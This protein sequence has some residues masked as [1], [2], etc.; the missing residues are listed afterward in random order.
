MSLTNSSTA[1]ATRP[2]LK[3]LIDVALLRN[4]A[5]SLG[6]VEVKQK[7]NTMLLYP[8]QVD[9]KQVGALTAA[10]RGRVLLSAGA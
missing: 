7:G 5:A 3:G 6:I 4:T 10:M 2:L 1:L 9:M 8:E